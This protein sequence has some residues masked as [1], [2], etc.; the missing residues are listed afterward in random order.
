MRQPF[1]LQTFSYITLQCRNILLKCRY[2]LFGNCTDRAWHLAPKTL[3]YGDVARFLQFVDLHTQVSCRC[4][5][6]LLEIDEVGTLN[7][8]QNGHYGQAQFGV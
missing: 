8:Q 1:F 5:G 6:L 7:T 4:F 3:F 2:T